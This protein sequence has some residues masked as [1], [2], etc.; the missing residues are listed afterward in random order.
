MAKATIRN[1][2]NK[3]NTGSELSFIKNMHIEI[4]G[5]YFGSALKNGIFKYLLLPFK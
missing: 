1:K 5:T 2:N 3:S 4:I